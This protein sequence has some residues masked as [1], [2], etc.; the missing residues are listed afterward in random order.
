MN[1]ITALHPAVYGRPKSKKKT[2]AREFGVS[3]LAI[4]LAVVFFIVV[5]SAWLLRLAFNAINS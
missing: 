1:I 3:G 2:V 5:L 4:S